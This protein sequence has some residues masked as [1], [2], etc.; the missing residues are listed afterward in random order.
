MIVQYF[1]QA[2]RS[3][4]KNKVFTVFNIIGFAIGFTVCVTIALY[5]YNEATVND[6]IPNV[7]NT[8][9]LVDEENET[10]YFDHTIASTLKDRFSEIEEVT[11]MFYLADPS[12]NMPI[13]IGEKQSEVAQLISVNNSFFDFMGVDVL[14]TKQ[15]NLFPTS[16]SVVI[17]KS[18]ALKLF[19]HID[20]IDEPVSFLGLTLTV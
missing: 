4:A 20:V 7:E 19:G 3:L 1:K 17:N 18:T 2:I 14:I 15:K 13:I 12:V 16:K 10:H 11:T 9:R 8:Y 5:V 6:F